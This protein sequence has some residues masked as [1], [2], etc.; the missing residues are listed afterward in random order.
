[1]NGYVDIHT[2]ILPGV[3]DGAADMSQALSLVRMA[4]KNGTRTMF[5]TPHY[6]GKY[7]KNDPQNLAETFEYFCE[8]V[9]QELP[10][11]KL[12]LGNEIY[13]QQEAPERLSAG[14]ILSMNGS[15]YC[16]LEFQPSSL[17]SQVIS[18]VSEMVRNGFI[19]IIAHAERYNIF[20]KDKTLTDEVLEIGALIQLNADSI[21][22]KHGLGVSLFCKKLLKEQK[23]HFV[24]SDAH[25]TKNRAPLLRDCWWKVYKLCGREYAIK[26]FYDNAQWIITNE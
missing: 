17:R 6:R 4:Y 10:G 24:A 5:L 1:M 15:R 2:H 16:L 9:N 23:A 20:R 21:M 13:Y 26:L 18:G 12:Y 25:D 19:P 7:K 14:R 11:M 22:G 8:M 3:D